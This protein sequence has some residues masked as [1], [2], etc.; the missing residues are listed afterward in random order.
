MIFP[1]RKKFNIEYTDEMRDF[2]KKLLNKD[3]NKRLGNSVNDVK[4][5]KE[6]AWF[7]NYDWDEVI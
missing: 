2:L 5:L 1:D 6:H 7:K 4:E 3:R